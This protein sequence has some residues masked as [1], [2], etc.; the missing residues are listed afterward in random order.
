[1]SKVVMRF[2]CCYLALT[3]KVSLACFLSNPC[4]TPPQNKMP[5]I[6]VRH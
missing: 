2:F 4:L 6:Y 5:Y 1:M 3:N